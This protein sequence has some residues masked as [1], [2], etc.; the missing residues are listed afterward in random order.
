[1]HVSRAGGNGGSPSSCW[2]KCP[3]L[4][5]DP[6]IANSCNL[7]FHPLEAVSRW[8]DPQLQVGENY[9]YLSK[10]RQ[11]IFTFSL[12]EETFNF[13]N[14]LFQVLIYEGFNRDWAV[15]GSGNWTGCAGCMTGRDYSW[16][17]VWG[18]VGCG[19]GGGRVTRIMWLR[20]LPAG[21]HPRKLQKLN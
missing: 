4:Y 3:S 1:M 9:S 16:G 15:K 12:I 11:I 18:V 20:Q 6:F 17:A 21:C 19:L 14:V 8:R 2:L 5:M 13:K 7:N 10:W